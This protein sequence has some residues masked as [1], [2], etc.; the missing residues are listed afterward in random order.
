MVAEP[1]NM[2]AVGLLRLEA[3]QA[4]KELKAVVCGLNEYEA[5][6]MPHFEGRADIWHG[7][8]LG[9]IHHLAACK[10]MYASAA[11]CGGEATWNDCF[12]Q[13]ET[14]GPSLDAAIAYLD[15]SHAYWLG[16]WADLPDSELVVPRQTNWGDRW[17]TWKLI[18]TIT[19]HDAY[20]AG[21]INALCAIARPTHEPPV[22]PDP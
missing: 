13:I 14:L 5:W 3:E 2:T 20:H 15:E 22:T 1:V 18:H 4:Y 16:S 21:Q 11:F 12:S 6:A 7:P 10:V 17:P 19:Q 8:P 9:I